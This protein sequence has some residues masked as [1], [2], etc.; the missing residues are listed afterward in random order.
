MDTHNMNSSMMTLMSFYGIKE[1]KSFNIKALG[2]TEE[3]YSVCVNINNF[4]PFFYIKIPDKWTKND[5]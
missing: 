3:G 5:S 4:K 1:V 2:V